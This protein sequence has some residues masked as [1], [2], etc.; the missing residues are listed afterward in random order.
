MI[1][2]TPLFHPDG[3]DPAALE[4]PLY[5]TTIRPAQS[6]TRTGFW[7]VMLLC[8]LPALASSIS[9]WRMGLWPIAGFFG[10][11]ILVLF[12]A[13][14]ISQLRSHSLEEVTIWPFEILVRRTPHRG[15]S[16]EWRLNPLWTRI[17][18]VEDDEYGV[19]VLSLVS[20][21]QRV[22]VARDAAPAQR[23]GVATDLTHALARAKKGY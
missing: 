13:L 4:Q 10:L 19:Q 18:C 22:V 12:A 3:C 16:Q 15:K 17:S 8:C 11:D 2:K 5:A 20:R 9:F 7:L 1:D 14:K 6:L 21:R 23:A